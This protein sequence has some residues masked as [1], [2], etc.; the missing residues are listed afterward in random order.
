MNTRKTLLSLAIGVSMC[1]AVH[2]DLLGLGGNA[3]A[4]GG[5]VSG[6]DMRTADSLAGD[7]GIGARG[8]GAV[9][10][11]TDVWATSER[12]QSESAGVVSWTMQSGVAVGQEVSGTARAQSRAAIR[13]ADR[14]AERATAQAAVA[15]DGAYQSSTAATSNVD[16]AGYASG[17]A[18][19]VATSNVG[20]A[21]GNVS[22]ANAGVATSNSA[23]AGASGDSSNGFDAN[24][25]GEFESNVAASAS[26][27]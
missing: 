3:A 21:A 19:G 2:A 1:G 23:R 12:A 9:D 6:I 20:S 24:V 18:A 22:G 13:R 17:T 4:G 8:H 16:T 10:A 26:S 14:A 7:V 11:A 27:N 25:E 15:A 5:I